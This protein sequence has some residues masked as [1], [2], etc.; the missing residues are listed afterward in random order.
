MVQDNQL[1]KVTFSSSGEQLLLGIAKNGMSVKLDACL[2]EDP[3][4]LT[5]RTDH[6]MDVTLCFL[7]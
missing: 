3:E 1:E 4:L 2:P 6:K 5:Q 7:H